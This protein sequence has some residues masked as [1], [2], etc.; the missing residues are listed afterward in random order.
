ML[1]KNIYLTYPA[2]YTGSYINWLIHVSDRDLTQHTVRDPMTD[3]SNTHAHVRIPTHQNFNKTMTWILYNRPVEK[4]VFPINTVENEKD[5]PVKA[6]YAV[7]N[8]LR[9]DPDPVIINI[10][11]NNDLDTR[12]FAAINMATKWGIYLDVK[13]LWKDDYNPFHD[14]DQE[15]AVDWLVNHW[16]EL[17]PNNPPLNR[18]EVEWHLKKQRRWFELRNGQASWEVTQDQYL[19]PESIPSTV[20]DVNVKDTVSAEFIDIIGDIL[21]DSGAGDFDF[22][23]AKEFHPTFVQRQPNRV[24]FDDIETYRATGEVSAFLDSN[25]LTRAFVREE[26]RG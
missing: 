14:P 1:K 2:G 26:S 15:K 19:L 16:K 17:I 10:H 12:K 25:I 8:I 20:Y 22:S 11:D 3:V 18:G 9:F 6:A 5:Y 23:Y 24:W 21:Q 13:G 4:K 7:Q